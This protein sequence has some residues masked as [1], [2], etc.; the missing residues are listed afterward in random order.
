MTVFKRGRIWWMEFRFKGMRI[1]ESTK[2][3]NKEAARDA[4]RVRLNGLK[5][6]T[7]GISRDKPVSFGRAAKAWLE[8]NAHW[9][10]S[11]R[12]I[13]E[14]KLRHLGVLIDDKQKLRLQE[15]FGKKLLLEIDNDAISR[16]Q[17]KRKKEKAS[18]RE[19]NME[20][21]VLRM[22]LR[23][24]NRWHLLAPQ[25][26]PLRERET[27]GKALTPDEVSRLLA[28]ARK[29][30]SQSLYPALVLLLNTGLRSGEL[31]TMQWRQVDWIEHMLM[32]GRS[33]TKEGEGRMVPL[34]E[35][36]L[37]AL[38]EWRRCFDN[39]LPDH[40][41]FPT[42]KYG[43]AGEA[44]HLR[45]EIMVYDRDPEKP[46]GSWKVAWNACRKAAGVKARLHDCRH[47]FCSRL[48]EAKV[49]E[50]TMVALAGWMS[51]K[52]LERY[53]HSRMEAKREA[54]KSA[55]SAGPYKNPYR[56]GLGV[57]GIVS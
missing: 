16:F 26:K 47:T 10:D 43:F 3:T 31:R 8:G 39:P 22:I 20:C 13:M 24:N 28:A 49:S 36:A 11:T 52:M 18:A 2:M 48:G 19:I 9:S 27:P 55:S 38:T 42:E 51:R 56:A 35:E 5:D 29:S 1:Q 57:K 41:I 37:E 32:V 46:I 44:G 50:A 14:L 4:E 53:S 30:R 7:A 15:P 23:K 21:A 12:E 25:Y 45:G 34:N 40:Y 6:A 17:T 54:V 33:K